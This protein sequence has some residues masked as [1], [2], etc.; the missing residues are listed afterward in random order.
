MKK[1][2]SD[3]KKGSIRK[4]KSPIGKKKSI[5]KSKSSKGKV[6]KKGKVKNKPSQKA[7]KV[8]SKGKS[9]SKVKKGLKSPLTAK[10]VKMPKLV[11]PKVRKKRTVYG[12]ILIYRGMK[13]SLRFST[14]IKD[15]RKELVSLGCFYSYPKLIE[16][17]L[18]HIR[19]YLFYQNYPNEFY[20]CEKKFL[21]VAKRYYF[22]VAEEYFHNDGL[23]EVEYFRA[24][25][26][27]STI[28]Y[29]RELSLDARVRRYKSYP[30]YHEKI[31]DEYSRLWK[32]AEDFTYFEEIPSPEVTVYVAYEE[33]TSMIIIDFRLS[34]VSGHVLQ[35][36]IK[37]V[38]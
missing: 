8:S 20:P 26:T 27:E 13:L 9:I 24:K 17:S 35:E 38:V 34:K 23:N 2:K 15:I 21:E 14:T 32:A 28:M 7:R 22:I 1:G 31:N 30:D 11:I 5:R 19:Y 6:G 33:I 37:Y 4:S 3:S 36:F 25:H 10:K 18:K 16:L 29:F 12:D